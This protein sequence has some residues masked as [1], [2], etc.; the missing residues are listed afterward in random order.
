MEVADPFVPPVE[1]AGSTETHEAWSPTFGG[2]EVAADD[3]S[4][5][6]PNGAT[7]DA[8]DRA[9]QLAGRL[10]STVAELTQ[11]LA[12]SETE[13]SA[14]QRDRTGLQDK[15]QG[16]EREAAKAQ[17]LH[18]SLLEGGA[19][20]SSDDVRALKTLTEALTQD[21]DRLTTVFNVVQQASKI[22]AVVGV[23]AEMR[24]IVEEG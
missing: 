2:Y 21:P 9:K 6:S 23:Y 24:A 12:E 19:A 5:S 3:A 15:I 18:D 10:S 4:S 20:V 17:R 13:R 11:T 7:A 22:A 16:L 14:A 1:G 8:I